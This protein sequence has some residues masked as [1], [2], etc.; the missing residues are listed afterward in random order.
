MPKRPPSSVDDEQLGA[1]LGLRAVRLAAVGHL[2][3]QAGSEDEDPAIGKLGREPTA[4]AEEDV[5]LAA[6]VVGLVAR[7]VLDLAHADRAELASAPEREP[8]LAGMTRR[9]DRR[10]VG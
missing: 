7:R 2:I 10:P 4:Q 8:G 1:L 9:L 3:A 6:P 5:P